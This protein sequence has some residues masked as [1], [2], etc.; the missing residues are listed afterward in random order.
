V[1]LVSL[2]G[3]RVSRTPPDHLPDPPD[4]PAPPDRPALRL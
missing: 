3:S 1:G 4:S 2:V